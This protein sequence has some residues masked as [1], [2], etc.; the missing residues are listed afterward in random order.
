MQEVVLCFFPKKES[1]WLRCALAT[2]TAKRETTMLREDADLPLL[3]L[4][5]LLRVLPFLRDDP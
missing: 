3:L 1:V 2:E 5:L 4:L